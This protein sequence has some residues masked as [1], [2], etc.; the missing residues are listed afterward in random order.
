MTALISRRTVTHVMAPLVTAGVLLPGSG[1]LAVEGGEKVTERFYP[2]ARAPKKGLV[3]Y[4]DG[5]GQELHD[6]DGA[7][8]TQG[9]LTG[10][11]S[12]VEAA[13]S[14]GYDVLSVRSPGSDLWWTD[15]TTDADG[16]PPVEGGFSRA[17]KITHLTEAIDRART[18]RHANTET[19]W[20]VGYSGGSEF[21]T[22]AFFPAYANSMSKGGFLVFGGGG[23]SGLRADSFSAASKQNLS[24]NW[25]TG[26]DDVP[27][28]SPDQRDPFG[29]G[30][31]GIDRARGGYDGYTAAGFQGRTHA[32]WLP[33][34][35]HEEI[36]SVFGDHLGA[37]LDAY[38]TSAQ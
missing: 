27:R 18:E 20:L 34:Y 32:T 12:V 36:A 38:R 16:V 13:R 31:N 10:P 30:Y 21:I 3:V 7:S 29:K 35:D 8:S 1:A 14:R 15:D 23:V 6:T 5:D 37:V 22:G 26:L 19:L 2:A 4:L 17:D 11:G 25:V 24:L 33:G 28:D 9:G